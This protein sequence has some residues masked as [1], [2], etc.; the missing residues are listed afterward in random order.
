MLTKYGSFF[1]QNK[2]FHPYCEDEYPDEPYDGELNDEYSDDGW[3]YPSEESRCLVEYLAIFQII[4]IN[5]QE[6]LIQCI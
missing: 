6:H 4:H 5:Q 3:L 2:I 1:T